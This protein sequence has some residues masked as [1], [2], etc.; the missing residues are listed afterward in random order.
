MPDYRPLE[1]KEAWKAKDPI[2]RFEGF[3]ARSVLLDDEKR[4]TIAAEV[5]DTI[6]GAVKYAR[7]S[8]WPD[9]KEAYQDA[10]A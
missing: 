1:E 9:P 3:L 10:Y 5:A 8:S 4:T 7:D 2:K 6:R